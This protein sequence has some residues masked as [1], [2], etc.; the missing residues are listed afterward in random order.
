VSAFGVQPIQVPPLPASIEA[1]CRLQIAIQELAVEA[2]VSGSRQAALQA[3]SLDPV[4]PDM[5]TARSM[6]DELIAV[7]SRYLPQFA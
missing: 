6:L 2:A 5:S 7:H 3:L 4:V 1:L